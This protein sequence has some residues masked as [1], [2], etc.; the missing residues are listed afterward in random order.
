MHV[1]ILKLTL[2][3]AMRSNNRSRNRI[4]IVCVLCAQCPVFDVKQKRKRMHGIDNVS[5]MHR[6]LSF[7]I[8]IIT[9]LFFETTA[10]AKSNHSTNSYFPLMP[11]YIARNKETIELP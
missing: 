3:I 7:I 8:V 11:I 2:N 10:N 4:I 9:V 1:H 6:P 5:L